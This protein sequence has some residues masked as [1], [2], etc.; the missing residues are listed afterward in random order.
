MPPEE[1]DKT[2]EAMPLRVGTYVPDDLRTS[3]QRREETSPNVCGGKRR[4]RGER[5][6]RVVECDPRGTDTSR[7]ICAKSR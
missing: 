1:L 2:L 4:S 6:K 3:R 7:D 5:T